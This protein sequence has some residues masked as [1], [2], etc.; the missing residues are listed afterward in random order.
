[1]STELLG[2]RDDELSGLRASSPIA[3]PVIQRAAELEERLRRTLQALNEYHELP[4]IM[5][6]LAWQAIVVDIEGTLNREWLSR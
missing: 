4:D 2:I 6:Q 5:K 1:M 3:D